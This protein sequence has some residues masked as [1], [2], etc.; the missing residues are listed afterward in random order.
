MA[1]ITGEP[2][3]IKD[4]RSQSSASACQPRLVHGMCSLVALAAE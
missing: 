3:S 4:V 1:P 2:M